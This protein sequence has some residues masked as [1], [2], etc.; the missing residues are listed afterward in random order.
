MSILAAFIT[1]HPVTSIPEIGKGEEDIIY[2]TVASLERVGKRIAQLEPDTIV[3]ISAH[4]ESYSDY[5]QIS[6]GDV[7]IG[8]L[9]RFGG[10]NI[11]FRNYYDRRFVKALCEMCE[12]EGFPAGIDS[13][14]HHYLDHGTMI[15][16]YFINQQYRAYNLVRLGISGTSLHS[17]YRL[18]ELIKKVSNKLGRKTVVVASG[19][20]SHCLTHDAPYGF[21]EMGVKYDTR[22]I[23]SLETA[24]FMDLFG[25]GEDLIDIS[26]QCIHRAACIMAGILDRQSIETKIYSYE[27]P[28]GVG[29]C[30]AEFVTG[31]MDASRAFGDIYR[32][33]QLMEVDR[34]KQNEDEYVKLARQAIENYVK[35][36]TKL[37]IPSN[38]PSE[39]LGE[40]KGVFVTIRQNGALRGC[41]G[42][43][44]PIAKNLA[45][46]II[47][48][49][50]KAA[51]EDPRFDELNEEDLPYIFIS[52]DVI[53]DLIEVKSVT[54]LDPKIYGVVVE[55]GKRHATLLPG[56]ASVT[57]SEE[58]LALAKRKAGIPQNEKC[59]LYRF[60][61]QHH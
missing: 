8:S 34:V 10:A 46:E 21:N 20:L 17:H 39:M 48:N 25:F 11:T 54:D 32:S 13:E 60:S 41:L 45:Q 18:G 40:S 6:D 37:R 57:T 14:V 38:I 4:A 5:F 27:K 22:M 9:A 28:Q 16:L 33:R 50:M 61:V 43:T 36:S 7:A 51:T 47:T 24:N 59:R 19:D 1:P 31:G 42:S 23:K 26:K 58:Q 29:L 44:K 56:L 15:P 12:E 55:Q 3:L 2:K 52:V 53:Y 49:A 30:V 35:T